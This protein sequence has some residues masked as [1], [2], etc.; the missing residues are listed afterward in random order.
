VVLAGLQRLWA[1]FTL[2]VVVLSVAGA[3]LVD[4][5]STVPWFLPVGLVVAVALGVAAAVEAIDRGLRAASPRTDAEAR[6][7]VRSRLA[8]QIA[9]AEAP[10]L[11]AFALAVMLGPGWVVLVGGVASAATMLRVRPTRSRLRRLED[12]WRSAD[13]DVS[14]LRA[15]EGRPGSDTGT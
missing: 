3:V 2:T 9:L 15:G 10:T 12:G 14:A 6:G 13:R 11:L 4:V 8:T 5:T 1:G 7:E